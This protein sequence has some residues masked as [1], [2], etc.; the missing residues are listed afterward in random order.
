MIVNTLFFWLALDLLQLMC[1]AMDIAVMHT[2]L[3]ADPANKV[4]PESGSVALGFRMH[5]V[6]H[7][8]SCLNR[9]DEPQSG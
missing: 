4:C 9:Q 8:H 7:M 3:G 2:K 6:L 5:L 1:I